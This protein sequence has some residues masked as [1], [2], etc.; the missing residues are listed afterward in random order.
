MPVSKSVRE[1]IGKAI[2][3]STFRNALFENREEALKD[4]TLSDEE[5]SV[6]AN[7]DRATIEDAAAHV[8]MAPAW[9][10][11]VRVTIHFP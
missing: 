11:G 10:I 7:L 3:D 2:T 9:T 5:R 4:F 1:V 6:I 8:G